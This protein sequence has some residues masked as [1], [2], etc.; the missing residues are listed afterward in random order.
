[1]ITA[2][3]SEFKKFVFIDK[4]RLIIY[5]EMNIQDTDAFRRK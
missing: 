5:P 4:I 3:F 2:F 1:M